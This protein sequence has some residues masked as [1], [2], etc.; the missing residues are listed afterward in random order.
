VDWRGMK[1]RLMTQMQ[2]GTL[3]IMR[4]KRGRINE[5]NNIKFH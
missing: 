2:L 3:K 5:K 4:K 1:I